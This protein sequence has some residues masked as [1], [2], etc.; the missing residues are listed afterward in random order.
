MCNEGGIAGAEKKGF[1]WL[2]PENAVKPADLTCEKEQITEEK[3]K[4]QIRQ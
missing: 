1:M 3:N 2:I 4:W